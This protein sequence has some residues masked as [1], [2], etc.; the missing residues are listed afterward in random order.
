MADIGS[1]A[2]HPLRARGASGKIGSRPW[3]RYSTCIRG[4]HYIQVDRVRIADHSSDVALQ[5]SLTDRVKP[6]PFWLRT[7]DDNR[8]EPTWAANLGSSLT[9]ERGLREH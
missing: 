5:V 2:S 8:R 6:V 9:A 3:P 7:L 1:F 4:Q